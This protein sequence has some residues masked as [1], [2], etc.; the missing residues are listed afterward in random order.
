MDSG[1]KDGWIIALLAIMVPFI[2][3][4]IIIVP[5]YASAV[6]GLY[7]IYGEQIF[8]VWDRYNMIVSTYKQ[9]YHQWETMPNLDIGNFFLPTFGPLMIGCA[10]TLVL[11]Y[12]FIKYIRSVFS[13]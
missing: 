13:H 12:M 10:F 5:I 6:V 11:V 7:F 8:E 3:T 2:M 1:Y 4:A 9:L